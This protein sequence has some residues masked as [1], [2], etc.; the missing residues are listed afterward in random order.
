M[1]EVDTSLQEIAAASRF[2]SPSVRASRQHYRDNHTQTIL[3]SVYLRLSA[4]DAKWFT[5]L[6]L[7]NYQPVVLHEYT[8]LSNYHVL[9]PQLLKVR[10]DL[11]VTTE[12]L[13]HVNQV[14]DGN[15]DRVATILKPKLGTK[16]GRQPWFK[17]RS[18]KNCLDMVKGRNISV[19]QKMDGEYCQI[20][21]DISKGSDC[22]QIFS[23]SG[24]DSTNDRASLHG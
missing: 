10:D 12:L 19:E 2:S 13:R 8:V 5:R 20:H 14:G 15:D 22:I 23:K 9:L 1:E 24:K 16:V 4:R 3:S 11:T 21:I 6:I 17:G 18:I 7:K